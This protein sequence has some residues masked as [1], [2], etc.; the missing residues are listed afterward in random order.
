M[1]LP[2]TCAAST[3]S[4]KSPVRQYLKDQACTAQNKSN[5]QK[6]FN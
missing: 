6:I 2:V 4:L 5:Q 3:R 1:T